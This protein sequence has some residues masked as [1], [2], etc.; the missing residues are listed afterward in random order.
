MTAAGLDEIAKM[1]IAATGGL[2]SAGAAHYDAAG[3]GARLTATRGGD[4]SSA[5]GISGKAHG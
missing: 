5:H 2:R 3:P 4:R 1:L